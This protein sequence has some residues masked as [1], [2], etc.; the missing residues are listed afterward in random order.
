LLREL[1]LGGV[2]ILSSG[3]EFVGESGGDEFLHFFIN[4]ISDLRVKGDGVWS[5]DR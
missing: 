4:G 2:G 5:V 1:L 3:F